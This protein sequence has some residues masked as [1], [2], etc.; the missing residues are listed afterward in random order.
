MTTHRTMALVGCA[1]LIA[2]QGCAVP[3]PGDVQD[4]LDEQASAE[5]LDPCTGE[6]VGRVDAEADTYEI[7]GGYSLARED[8]DTLYTDAASVEQLVSAIC[9]G[10]VP[11]QKAVIAD[12]NCWAI[13]EEAHG[14]AA[15][16]AGCCWGG[17]GRYSCYEEC[18]DYSRS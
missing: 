9:S 13:Y 5:L 11:G 8:V 18:Y 7:E 16:C 12:G 3:E 14:S 6:V 4:Q 2:A 1:V 17:G 10:Q 15:G